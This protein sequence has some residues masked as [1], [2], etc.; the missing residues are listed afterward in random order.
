MVIEVEWRDGVVI[1]VVKINVFFMIVI[2]IK[3]VLRM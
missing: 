1:I 2:I 3:G